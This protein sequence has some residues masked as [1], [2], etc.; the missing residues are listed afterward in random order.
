MK[1]YR[2]VLLSRVPEGQRRSARA[3]VQHHRLPS[4]GSLRAL[5]QKLEGS[6]SHSGGGGKVPIP[7]NKPTI[8]S[9]TNQ[10]S[11]KFQVKGNDFLKSHAVH[12]RVVNV[13]TFASDFFQATS[14]REGNLDNTLTIAP[15]VPGTKLSFSA[16]DE[17]LDSTD[18]T[19]TLWSNTFEITV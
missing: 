9:V 17:R 1:S 14:D 15:Q 5:I 6:D 2:Q 18:T 19:G 13:A 16:N 7:P 10:G 4:P 8:N 11:G 12:I 3:L